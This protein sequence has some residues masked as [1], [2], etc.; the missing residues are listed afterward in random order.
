L[1]RQRR[2][3]RRMAA[4]TVA[5]GRARSARPPETRRVPIFRPRQRSR[6]KFT[7]P[8]IWSATPSGVV[9]NDADAIP[10]VSRFARDHRLPYETPSGVLR[11]AHAAEAI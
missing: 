6:R 1:P 8:V 7:P 2:E 3:S 5:G 10:V 4:R 9:K 11:A